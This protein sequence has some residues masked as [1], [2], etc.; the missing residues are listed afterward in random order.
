MDPEIAASYLT[1]PGTHGQPASNCENQELTEA[2]SLRNSLSLSTVP[3]DRI[4]DIL[5]LMS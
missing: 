2:L 5:L 1:A 4:H 3:K